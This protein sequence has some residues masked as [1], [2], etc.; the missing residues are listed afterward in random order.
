MCQDGKLFVLQS[1]CLLHLISGMLK[2]FQALLFGKIVCLDC[3]QL[4][5]NITNLERLIKFWTWLQEC[6]DTYVILQRDPAKKL[7]K[8][9]R[10]GNQYLNLIFEIL[11]LI[12]NIILS[13]KIYKLIL[14]CFDFN[15][16]I[17]VCDGRFLLIIL[18]YFSKNAWVRF[19]TPIEFKVFK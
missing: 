18:R 19:P 15:S 6:L 11:D 9:Y 1:Q 3:W 4:F 7:P 5:F 8:I 13:R 10:V 14:H 16:Y 12:S 17:C 2:L